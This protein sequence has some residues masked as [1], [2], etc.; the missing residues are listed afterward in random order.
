MVWPGVY[1][2]WW[3]GPDFPKMPPPEE[4]MLIIIPENSASNFLS[5]QQAIATPQPLFLR[6][7][8]KNHSEVITQ[9]PRVSALPG[10]QC[11][12]W[13][14]YKNGVSISLSPMELLWDKDH[15]CPSMPNALLAPPPNA[16]SPAWEPD[17]TLTPHCRASVIQLLSSL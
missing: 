5:P 13:V 9:I 15:H 10:A 3:V 1:Q 6:R 14:P 11:T 7:S 17:R 12:W 4:H 8:S 16:R 2:P